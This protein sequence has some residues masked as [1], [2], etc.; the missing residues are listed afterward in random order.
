MVSSK[1]TVSS[2]V[3]SP[4]H[5]SWLLSA[6]LASRRTVHGSQLV[7]VSNS[8]LS[9]PVTTRRSSPIANSRVASWSITTSRGVSIVVRKW[10]RRYRPRPVPAPQPPEVLGTFPPVSGQRDLAFLGIDVAEVLDNLERAVLGP[11]DVHVH[12]HV[13]L[14]GHHLSGTS[15]TLWDAGVVESRDDVVLL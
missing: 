3:A 12:A 7:T 8:V 4:A 2:P 9:T 11:G 14:A 10:Q 13:V 6:W 5:R 1:L 15:W